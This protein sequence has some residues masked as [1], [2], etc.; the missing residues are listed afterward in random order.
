MGLFTLMTPPSS[1]AP[2]WF[3]DGE[4]DTQAAEADAHTKLLAFLGS[5]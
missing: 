2:D 1:S 3:L 4:A 5:Q